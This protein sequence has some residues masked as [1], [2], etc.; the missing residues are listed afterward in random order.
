MVK[1]NN[2]QVTISAAMLNCFKQVL[3]SQTN[4]VDLSP[5]VEDLGGEDITAVAVALAY[6][7]IKP[8]IDTTTRFDTEYRGTYAKYEF[9]SY[10]VIKDLVLI[11]KTYFTWEDNTHTW[12]SDSSQDM[13]IQLSRW[14]NMSTSEEDIKTKILAG[15]KQS[16]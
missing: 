4:G 7:G 15:C 16:K 6:K 9:K 12:S 2:T 1:S 13:E 5:I 10:S 11:S 3:F 14:L 8:E